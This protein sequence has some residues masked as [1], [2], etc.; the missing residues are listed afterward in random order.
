M[1]TLDSSVEGQTTTERNPLPEDIGE[2]VELIFKLK[3]S[4][5][6]KRLFIELYSK[7]SKTILEE[8]QM[9]NL[10]RRKKTYSYANQDRK[11]TFYA[12]S[13]VSKDSNQTY[14]TIVYKNNRE[15][16]DLNVVLERQLA[17]LTAQVDVPLSAM[18]RIDRI[19]LMDIFLRGFRVYR[20]V[21]YVPSKLIIND[22]K[23]K[24]EYSY[25]LPNGAI[26][27]TR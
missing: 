23:S 2:I 24:E 15:G 5:N 25:N 9:I 20:G 19:G 7:C 26:L 11:I 4:P 12:E 18:S 8:G 13:F 22:G 14:M 16:I 21:S 1:T 17:V 27:P 6:S 10:I 3:A